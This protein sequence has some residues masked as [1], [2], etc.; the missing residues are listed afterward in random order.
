MSGIVA[1][2]GTLVLL[3]A[4]GALIAAG[5][6]K[7]FSAGWLLIAAILVL[8]NDVL[9]TRFYGLMPDLVGG[10]W[11]WQGKGLA[12]LATL[13]IVALPCFDRREAGFTI[14]PA[15]GSLVAA[16]PVALAYCT[17]FTFLALIFPNEPATGEDV[18]FQLT[19]PSLEEE[20]FY[21]GTLLYAL[22]RA[23]AG[24]LKFL[25]VEWSWGALLSCVL[26]GMA[27]AFGFADESFSLDLSTMALTAVPAFIAVWLRLRTGSLILPIVLHSFGNAI[28]LIL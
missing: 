19:M 18:A 9:L 5:D 14:A 13:A 8:V 23:F 11:N 1:I 24:R 16:L 3:L 28:F 12:L 7:G 10:V 2:A 25:G 21:R 6:R 20:M 15:T 4:A 27:H 17:F 22:D 26:F